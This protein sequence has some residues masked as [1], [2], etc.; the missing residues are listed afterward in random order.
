M[1]ATVHFFTANSL[2]SA[3]VQGRNLTFDS[4]LYLKQPPRGRDVLETTSPAADTT[5]AAASPAGVEIAYFQVE[6]GKSVYYEVTPQGADLAVAT[7]A[8][9]YAS[10][11]NTIPWGEGWRL[12]V[13]EKV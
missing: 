9:M 10:G 8:S 2:V 6:P 7:S 1:T 5:D 13:L 12:S 11:N 4:V 3:P